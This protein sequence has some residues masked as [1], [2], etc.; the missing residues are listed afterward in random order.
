MNMMK[1]T[2]RKIGLV[3]FNSS[4]Q[5]IGDGTEKV[6][7]ISNKE[8]L[9]SY[10]WLMENAQD[11]SKTHMTKGINAT[12]EHL[13]ASI[14]ETRVCGG[15]ALGP[16]ALSAIS[17][18][19]ECGEGASVVICTDGVS[20][21]GIGNLADISRGVKTQDEID[22]FYE[23][24]ANQANDNGVSVNLISIKGE[25]CDIETL[26]TLSD[27]TGGEINIIDP[28]NAGDEF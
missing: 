3:T 4:V 20:N 11:I 22:E 17:M 12:W 27:K 23:K 26:M 6:Q 18:A 19:G 7:I 14:I 24:L 1:D 15:T 25:N 28:L 8:D 9:Y 21:H 2:K 13:S 16:A 5:L 10:D